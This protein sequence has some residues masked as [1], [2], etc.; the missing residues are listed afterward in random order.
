MKSDEWE[1]CSMLKSRCAD[2]TCR[3]AFKLASR[4]KACRDLLG[5]PERKGKWSLHRTRWTMKLITSRC[6]GICGYDRSIRAVSS[7]PAISTL[8]N[9]GRFWISNS[10]F[11]S[12]DSICSQVASFAFCG[13][14]SDMYRAISA[15]LRRCKLYDMLVGSESG[16]PWTLGLPRSSSLIFL[17]ILEPIR[18][19]WTR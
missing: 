11:E 15:I 12:S 16:R 3:A 18:S 5:C 19:G 8:K 9:A 1:I 7:E 14:T 4:D 13:I 6:I 10:S 17:G 2:S